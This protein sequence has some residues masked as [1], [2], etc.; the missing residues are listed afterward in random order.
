MCRHS[1]RGRGVESEIYDRGKEWM[2]MQRE[3]E[4]EGGGRESESEIIERGIEWMCM[5]RERGGGRGVR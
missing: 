5:H 4:R 1:D 2:C 3:R